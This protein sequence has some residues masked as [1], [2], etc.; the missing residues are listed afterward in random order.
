MSFEEHLR[1]KHTEAIYEAT[2]LFQQELNTGRQ[3][4]HW[5]L[6]DAG[7]ALAVGGIEMPWGHSSQR[8]S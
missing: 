8:D 7:S 1:E 2:E 5:S 3:G 4:R 6:S